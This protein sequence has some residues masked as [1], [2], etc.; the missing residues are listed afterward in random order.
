M[1][2]N[3][4][5]TASSRCSA[6]H[7]YHI[8]I[9]KVSHF[10]SRPRSSVRCPVSRVRNKPTV[11]LLP[12]GSVGDNYLC[13][14]RGRVG[15]GG[16]ATYGV[17]YPICIE[18]LFSCLWFSLADRGIG[19]MQEF[20]RYQLRAIFPGTYR[21]HGAIMVVLDAVAAFLSSPPSAR[22][23]PPQIAADSLR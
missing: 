19:T 4:S 1:Y 11:L 13:P 16:Y 20:R 8:S 23:G 12:M 17:G 9:H 2:S 6:Q 21:H 7:F 14:W 15:N 22:P 18:G 10:H 5:S 3:S